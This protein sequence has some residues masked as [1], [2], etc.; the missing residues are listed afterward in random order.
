MF[1]T[2]FVNTITTVLPSHTHSDM[3]EICYLAKGSQK[4]FVGNNIFKLYG[5]DIFI[6]FPN[7]IH[8]TGDHP[9]EKGILYWMVLKRPEKEKDYLGLSY[10]NAH[11][12]FSKLLHLPKRLFKGGSECKQI[13]GM[14]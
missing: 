10:P 9:E 7:E 13:I 12:L 11:E 6:T 4:Y 2:S 14:T 8:G 5:G 3:I 1:S